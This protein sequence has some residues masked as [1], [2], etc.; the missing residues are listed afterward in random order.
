MTKSETSPKPAHAEGGL[1]A[2]ASLHLHPDQSGG[3]M[4]DV[5]QFTLVEGRGIA[6]DTRYF[7]RPSRRKVTL[8]GREQLDEHA[9]VLGLDTIA[10]GLARSNIETTG[11]DL[12]ALI[13]RDVQVGGAVLRFYEART[14]CHQMDA[15]APG[16]RRL[17]E[18]GR[19]GV[20]AQVVRGGVVR[21][22]DTV[23]GARA[24]DDRV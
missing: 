18:G 7:D 4:I 8:I 3:P 22:R 5:D 19:Q 21:V 14:P 16:L 20:L 2:V 12:V 24:A 17:M 10:P 23:S 1:G 11:I 9:G 15:V 13:G 6:E